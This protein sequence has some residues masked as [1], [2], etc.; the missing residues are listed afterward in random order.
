MV[1]RLRIGL[2]IRCDSASAVAVAG[3]DIVASAATPFTD[4]SDLARSL[5]DLL[6][7]M[8]RHGIARPRLIVA[9]GPSHCQLR[10]LVG[11]PPVRSAR[12]ASGILRLNAKRFFLQQATGLVPSSV[13]A[14]RDG[15]W[16]A[17]A[18]DTQLTSA[19]HAAASAHRLRVVAVLPTMTLWGTG[20]AAD[21]RDLVWHDG[22]HAVRAT[23]D[24]GRFVDCARVPESTP[25]R[26][27]LD[28]QVTRHLAS[29]K[30]ATS[31]AADAYLAAEVDRVD[32]FPAITT[33]T[34]AGVSPISR[35]RLAVSALAAVTSV[36]I[37]IAAPV[38]VAQRAT[39]VAYNSAERIAQEA[40]P[41]LA[42]AARLSRARSEIHE[43]RQ[44]LGE[45][46]APSS[47]IIALIARGLPDS[48][49]AI[50]VRIDS[51]HGEMVVLAPKAAAVLSRIERT[52]G[53]A[54]A[55][56][57]GPITR[58]TADGRE[59]ERITLRFSR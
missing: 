53:P 41:A 20:L 49:A 24:K 42:N 18:V 11:L 21:A 45:S 6:A 2:A 12:E 56:V 39:V 15:Q 37:A 27:P 57:T 9:V 31:A 7:R 33:E 47:K 13:I 29:E 28:A 40:A 22:S 51:V 35:W 50:S 59:R 16:W 3:G 58:E 19:L 52:R 23:F 34:Q 10:R 25:A 8:P 32:V 17:A 44:L 36:I 26:L 14:V 38:L 46:V 55:S 4:L 30:G 43:V 1:A 5:T 54:N 48:A